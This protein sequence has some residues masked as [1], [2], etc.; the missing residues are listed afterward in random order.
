VLYQ[1]WRVQAIM[2]AGFVANER[3]RCATADC[4][5]VQQS[6][7]IAPIHAT[8][9]QLCAPGIADAAQRRRNRGVARRSNY[10]DRATSSFMISVVPA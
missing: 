8:K 6:G 1:D 10:S 2:V 5:L 9:L 7:A 3:L 4:T